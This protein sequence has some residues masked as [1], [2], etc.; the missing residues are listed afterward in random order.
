MESQLHDVME[1][2]LG[3]PPHQVSP[4]QCA[5]GCAGAG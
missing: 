1:T 3:E 5:A 2:V 4:K